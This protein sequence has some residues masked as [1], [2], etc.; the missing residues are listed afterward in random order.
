MYPRITAAVERALLRVKAGETAYSAAKAEG[1]ALST[2][3][4]AVKRMREAP[5]RR[6]PPKK[7]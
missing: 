7:P 2:I 1:I 4:R 5:K 6:K 3:Y